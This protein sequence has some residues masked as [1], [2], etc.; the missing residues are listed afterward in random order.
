[1]NVQIEFEVTE[2]NVYPNEDNE[3]NIFYF[4]GDSMVINF[5][6]KDEEVISQSEISREDAIRLA[7]L[8]LHLYT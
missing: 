6:D 5:A 2:F 1:M 7:R 4:H 8:I 3:K